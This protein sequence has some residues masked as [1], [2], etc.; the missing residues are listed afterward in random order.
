MPLKHA[1]TLVKIGWT[2]T[3]E[4]KKTIEK[5]AHARRYNGVSEL[6]RDIFQAWI[7]EVQA[8]A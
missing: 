5:E 6:V 8:G 3:E 2:I 1:E 7:D 4:Q